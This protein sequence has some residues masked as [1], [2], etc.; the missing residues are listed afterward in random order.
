MRERAP[1]QEDEA[2]AEINLSPLIDI[3]F[4]LLIFFMVTSVFVEETGVTVQQPQALTAESLERQSLLLALTAE[5]EVRF[6]GEVV[7]LNSVRGLVARLQRES[8]RPVIILADEASRSGLLVQLMDE[9]R[10]GGA[11][12]VSVAA[13]VRR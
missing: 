9:C 1:W 8:E 12:Q 6:D 13:E 5:G 4:L 11:A 2:A 7:P 10:L 3:V